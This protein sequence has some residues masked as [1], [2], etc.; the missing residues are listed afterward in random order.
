MS[1]L[2]FS[3]GR[4]GTNMLLESL[5]G[6]SMLRATT[7]TEDKQVFR[8]CRSLPS[9]Y[10]S[11]CDTVYVDNVE[12]VAALL[13]KNQDL[14]IL[15]TIR[16]IRDM[17]LSKIYRGQPGNDSPVVADDATFDGCIDDISRM[18]M[19]YRYVVENFAD[20]MMLVKVEDMVLE[21]DDTIALICSFCNIKFED[22]MRNF[23]GRYRNKHQ[24]QRYSNLDKSQVE[25]YK[26]KHEIYNGFFKTH[27][28][29][30]ENLFDKLHIYL[31]EFGYE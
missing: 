27:D 23:V 7:V 3:C 19:F 15:W 2:I 11:K 20:R 8:E 31:Q 18:A 14:K 6:S 24:A 21:Y 29:D 1:V 12:Q 17:A 22:N 4:T 26:R 16:D 10:L 30:L 9:Y 25:L 13:N 5:R 28:I